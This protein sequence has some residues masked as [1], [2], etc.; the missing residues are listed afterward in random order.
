MKI[1]GF[2]FI[3]NGNALGYPFVPAIR[4]LLPLCDEVIVNV[5]RSTD[6][7]LDSVRAIRD[8]KIRII[9]SDW[10]EREK[11]GDP[12]MRRHTDLALDQCTGDWCVYIQGDEVLHEE[13]IPAMRASMERELDNPR[14]QAL[15]VNYTH[16]YGSFWTEVYSFGWYYQEVRVV[17]RDPKI[18]ACGGAQGFRADGQKLWVKNSGGRYFHY[19]YA[20]E[21]NQARVK[22]GNLADVYG[23]KQG[24]Q[25]L[26][27]R[28]A[29]F[30]DNDQKVKRFTGT[31]PAAMSDLAAQATWTYVS[32][33][34]L[35]RFRRE[36]FW[37]DIALLVKRCTGLTLGVHR[38]YRLLK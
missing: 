1:S 29:R 5:P 11:T 28:P 20:L 2:T 14:V 18:R 6:G 23:N 24:V 15:L 17:R 13:S 26:A 22:I 12:I 27:Q 7:T 34:P 37:E 32:R 30:Y 33:N 25:D 4:S 31:H 36:Y 19:G 16:F 9:E 21:P 3:R 38:N 8:P 10:D 35:I